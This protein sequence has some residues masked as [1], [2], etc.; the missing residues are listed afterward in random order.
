MPSRKDATLSERKSQGYRACDVRM[1]WLGKGPS[2]TKSLHYG[3]PYY[4]D[5]H[6]IKVDEQRG[7]FITTHGEPHNTGPG[8]L[9]V[10]DI[11]D[12][13]PIWSID[14]VRSP[15]PH[16]QLSFFN[17]DEISITFANTHIA[18]TEKVSSSLIVQAI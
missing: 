6:R 10:A 11:S 14:S 7:F 8:R 12:G 13:S 1:S 3:P 18:N 15:I 5:V 4:P 16:T 2:R 17:P 9:I